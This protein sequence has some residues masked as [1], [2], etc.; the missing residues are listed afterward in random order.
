MWP[1]NNWHPPVEKKN[2]GDHSTMKISQI[3]V[4]AAIA[5]LSMSGLNAGEQVSSPKVTASSH[6]FTSYVTDATIY[7]KKPVLQSAVTVAWKNGFWLNVW[8]SIG[9]KNTFANEIDYTI[10]YGQTVFG[11]DL[12]VSLSYFDVI[13][14]GHADGDV[15]KLTL[16]ASKTWSIGAHALTPFVESDY[17]RPVYPGNRDRFAYLE[18][19]WVHEFGLRHSVALSRVLTFS[20]SLSWIHDCGPFGNDTGEIVQYQAGLAVQVTKQLSLDIGARYYSLASPF[21]ADSRRDSGNQIVG[22]GGVKVSF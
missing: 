9:E 5:A 18:Q 10:G 16:S 12:G 4:L 21:E 1:Y 15:L 20:H 14:L 7:H 2:Q 17:Y 11:I 19:G 3:A 8:D 22:F 13:D 6:I